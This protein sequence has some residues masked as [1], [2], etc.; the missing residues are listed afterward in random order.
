MEKISTQKTLKSDI[1]IRLVKEVDATSVLQIYAPYVLSSAATFET[2][3]PSIEL[4]KD[5]IKTYS[6]SSPWLVAEVEGNV[7]GYAYA[8]A[9]RGRSAY[10]WTQETTVYLN[11]AYQQRGIAK[12]LYEKLIE[13]MTFMGFTKAI[14]VI[15]LP[16]NASIGLHQS[17]GFKHIGKF[18]DIGFKFNQWHTTSWWTLD[19][20]PRGYEPSPIKPISSL[21]TLIN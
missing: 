15:T 4:F 8:S 17:L 19:I 11:P 20:Q 16:N 7:V 2:E 14:G 1:N 10:Q 3:V 6:A 12:L 5:R 9:H 18:K 13:L 21:T